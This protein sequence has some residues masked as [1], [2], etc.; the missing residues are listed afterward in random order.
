MGPT[1]ADPFGGGALDIFDVLERVESLQVAT[2]TVPA[3][4]IVADAATGPQTTMLSETPDP[5][6]SKPAEAVAA[7]E[8]EPFVGALVQPVVIDEAAPATERKRGWWRR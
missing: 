6:I 8:S 7:N 3:D 1:P 4:A 5:G 2:V